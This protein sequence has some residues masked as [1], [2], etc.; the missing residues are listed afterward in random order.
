[1]QRSIARCDDSRHLPRLESKPSYSES[2]KAGP[3]SSVGHDVLAD[4][5]FLQQADRGTTFKK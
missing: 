3:C 1:M 5:D 4:I 2:P